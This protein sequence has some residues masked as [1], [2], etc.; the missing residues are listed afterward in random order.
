MILEVLPGGARGQ[1]RHNHAVLRPLAIF[2]SQRQQR[3]RAQSRDEQST[4]SS[5]LTLK[6]R[7]GAR[8]SS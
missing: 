3:D 1:P 8:G 4:P 5:V 6:V 2:A 7:G